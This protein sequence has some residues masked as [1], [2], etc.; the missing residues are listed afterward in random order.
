MA[1]LPAQTSATP[2]PVFPDAASTR[3]PARTA[4]KPFFLTGVQLRVG[5]TNVTAAL[6][7]GPPEGGA[8]YPAICPRV[9]A[10]A[11]VIP[12]RAAPEIA[13]RETP[14]KDAILFQLAMPTPPRSSTRRQGTARPTALILSFSDSS[15]YAQ[16]WG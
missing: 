3:A 7:V 16:F 2:P 5:T 14:A 1:L 9:V 4:W 6:E 12:V 8:L 13:A 11:L 15:C 10:P